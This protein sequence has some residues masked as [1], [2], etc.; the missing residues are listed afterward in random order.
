LQRCGAAEIAKN[1]LSRLLIALCFVV[2]IHSASHAGAS[3]ADFY[4]N[5]SV[6]LIVGNGPGG[7]FDV[8]G[9]LLA[10]HIGKHIPGNPTVIV[11]NMP[12]AGTLLAANYLYNVAPKDGT[13]F[14]LIARNMPL[15]GLL[16]RNSNVRFDPRK[17]TWLGSSSDFSDDAY[18]LIVRKHGTA[19]SIADAR[20]AG[21]PP[22]VLGGTAEGA[23]S[24]D[25]PKILRDALGINMKL[26]LGYRDSA[27]IF[28]AMERGEVSGRTVELS[29]LRSTHPGWLESGGEY[30]MLVMYARAE[31]HPDFPDVPTARELAPND[32]A[33]SLIAF[34]ETPLLTMAWPFAAPPGMPEDRALAL[35]AAFAATHR[36]PDYLAAAAALNIGIHPV[37]AEQIYRTIDNLAGAPPE[38]F[39]YVR[40]LMGAEKGG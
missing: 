27:A 29:S 19:N 35:R 34:T 16:G 12:G 10:R 37:R 6:T 21:A 23:S 40:S 22:L 31:R 39:D 32:M 4:R 33:R 3:V 25:V 18:V 14:G 36:D 38:L 7:G 1:V 24:A 30:R 15:L 20:R 28:L 17:F 13:Q 5:K 2:A 8:F 26:I 9:R 11:Q